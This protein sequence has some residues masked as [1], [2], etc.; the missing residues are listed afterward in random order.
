MN[1]LYYIIPSVL[2]VIAVLAYLFSRPA[3]TSGESSID[4]V[5]KTNNYNTLPI[6]KTSARTEQSEIVKDKEVFKLPNKKTVSVP[7]KPRVYSIET[8][9]QPNKEPKSTLIIKTDGKT[10]KIPMKTVSV[11]VEDKIKFYPKLNLGINSGINNSLNPTVIPNLSV[12]LL[13]NST[14]EILAIGA[15]Y[16]LVSRE[17]VVILSTV[18]RKLPILENSYIGI[19]LGADLKQNYSLGIGVKVKL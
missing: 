14:W 11:K 3:V 17:P 2:A 15:G 5:I 18:Y 19:D 12:S 13:N 16:D 7:I 4:N 6:I 8:T 10:Y 9:I 1:K